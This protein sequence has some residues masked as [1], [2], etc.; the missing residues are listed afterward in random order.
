MFVLLQSY[1]NTLI[2]HAPEPTSAISSS[3][4]DRTG[5]TWSPSSSRCLWTWSG[6]CRPGSATS[7]P[8]ERWSRS[9]SSS[10][11]ST[12]WARKY[13]R[14]RWPPLTSFS[15]FQNWALSNRMLKRWR[16]CFGNRGSWIQSQSFHVDQATFTFWKVWLPCSS[17]A[18]VQPSFP[19]AVNRKQKSKKVYIAFFF[20]SV[21]LSFL[22]VVYVYQLKKRRAEHRSFSL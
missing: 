17:I 14:G 12:S 7:S 5:P 8:T 3:P 1:K 10:S 16:F 19:S 18:V 9:S 2:F 22:I 20:I 6:R 13:W 4:W 15:E 21:Y 11:T